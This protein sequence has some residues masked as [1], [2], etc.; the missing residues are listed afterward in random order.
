MNTEFNC[1][2]VKD[3]IQE[4]SKYPPDMLVAAYSS[5]GED[6]DLIFKVRLESTLDEDEDAMSY[7]KTLHVCE[8]YDLEEVLV[9]G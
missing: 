7:C 1:F 8:I 3:L 5:V 9:I 6:M 2:T 4:L